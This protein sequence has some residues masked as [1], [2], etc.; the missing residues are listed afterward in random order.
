MIQPWQW[1]RRLVKYCGAS[2]LIRR[3]GRAADQGAQ[4]RRR[5]HA[6]TPSGGRAS[7]SNQG[8]QPCRRLHTATPPCRRASASNQS[9]QP[10]RRLQRA[11]RCTPEHRAQALWRRDTLRA[12]GRL[13]SVTCPPASNQRTQPCRGL[14]AGPAGAGAGRGAAEPGPAARRHRELTRTLCTRRRLRLGIFCRGRCCG[15]R[16]RSAIRDRLRK[17]VAPYEYHG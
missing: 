2:Q 4:S 8:A 10:C 14:G 15:L 11:A 3:C 6:T 9:S 16:Y 1:R 17:P 7:A 12:P 5:F 13:V